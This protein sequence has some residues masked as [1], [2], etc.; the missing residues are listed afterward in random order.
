MLMRESLPDGGFALAKGR[1]RTVF[2]ELAAGVVLIVASGP[3]EESLDVEVLQELS[4]A[5]E[6]YGSLTVFADLS[7][8]SGIS[9]GSSRVAVKWV[10]RH[11]AAILAGHLLVGQVAV[12]IAV[13]M[14]AS[15]FGGSVR[16]YTQKALFEAGIRRQV[17]DF[18]GL[19]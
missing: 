11:R 19:S 18:I 10:R 16:S 15:V 4:R 17:P 2:R 9:L 7:Q 13:S 12:S 8:L 1:S 14:I 3:G 5:I 6:R